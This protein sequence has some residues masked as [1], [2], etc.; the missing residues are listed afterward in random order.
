MRKALV[1][2]DGCESERK[3]GRWGAI[4]L[5]GQNMCRAIASAPEAEGAKAP[6]LLSRRRKDFFQQGI[7]RLLPARKVH[8]GDVVGL[9]VIVQRHRRFELGDRLRDERGAGL[10]VVRTHGSAPSIKRPGVD[11]LSA[12]F[13]FVGREEKTCGGHIQVGEEFGLQR[14][15]QGDCVVPAQRRFFQQAFEQRAGCVRNRSLTAENKSEMRSLSLGRDASSRSSP[16]LTSVS[17]A[18]GTAG[19]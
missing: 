2:L 15:A 6:R 13:R 9:Q 16:K 5:S 19:S 14:I 7:Q 1:P 18:P 17:R 3:K 12:V 8:G 11:L 10:L 4:P